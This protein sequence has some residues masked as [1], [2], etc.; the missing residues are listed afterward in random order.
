MSLVDMV[1]ECGRKVQQLLPELPRPEQKALGWLVSGV[2]VGQSAALSRAGA[3]VPGRAKDSSKQ[4]R[5]QR[6]M[7]NPRLDVARAQRR[8]LAH[9]L[10]HRHGRLDLLLD[11]TTT[12]AT[13]HRAG[14][15]T[16]CFAVAWH[17]RALPLVWRSWVA[18]EKAQRWTEA[19]EEMAQTIAACVRDDVQVVVMADR[20]LSSSGL[21][22]IVH[23]LGWHYLLRVIKTTRV[24]QQDAG[25]CQIGELIPQPG[26]CYLWN[27]RVYAPRFKRDCWVSRWEDA[28]VTNVVAVWRRAEE[29]SWLL[30]TDLPAC[31]ARCSEYRRRTWEEE[32][33]RDLKSFGWQWQRSRVRR[34]ERVDRLL[35][36]LALAT[37][38]V[39]ALAQRVIK[40]GL[41]P[42]LEAR[43]RR[44]HSYFQLGLRWVRR[45]LANADPFPVTFSLWTESTA[46][47]KLS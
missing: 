16:L 31:A 42:L 15:V 36:V 6:L 19:I 41:R 11:A 46:P 9:V 33:F 28:L 23:G 5:A 7:A 14:T 39:A 27:V 38:W 8:L 40:R 4:R 32:L 24:W 35:L 18:D 1:Q 2:V 25:V 26:H 22:R 34:P 29:D 30:L 20:G 17:K 43:S 21:A 12:G 44:S 13:A 45:C 47:L 37:L 3:A 10:R